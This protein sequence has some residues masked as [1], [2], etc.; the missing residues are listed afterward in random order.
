MN[1]IIYYKGFYDKK[2]RFYKFAIFVNIIAVVLVV[3]YVG[4]RS[5][6]FAQDDTNVMLGESP[7]M[8]NELGVILSEGLWPEVEGSHSQNLVQSTSTSIATTTY[9]GSE[10]IGY[11][12]I[13]S[14]NI[15]YPIF[16][17]YSDELLKTSV[18]KFAGPNINEVGNLCILG[19][20]SYNNKFFSKVYEL[21][22]GD[23]IMLYD[24]NKNAFKYKVFDKTIINENDLNCLS[25]S[26]GGMK[27]LTLITCANN[28]HNRTIVKAILIH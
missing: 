9:K 5:F 28:A 10:I 26:T 4:L 15:N 25:Q 1:Q 23:E 2:I 24:I 19:H 6:D 17:T 13:K 21:N 22:I 14:L 16:A 7:V 12:E 18:C 3:F 27:I 20:N 11:I 8:L